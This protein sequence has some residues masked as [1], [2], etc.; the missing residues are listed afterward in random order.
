MIEF[1]LK[2]RLPQHYGINPDGVSVPIV[3]KN[4]PFTEVDAKACREASSNEYS[5]GVFNKFEKICSSCDHVVLKVDNNHHE[6]T[7]VKFEQYVN[8]LPKRIIDRKKRCDLL[9]TDG[10][11]HNKIVFC[12]LCCYD[13][14]YI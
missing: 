9:M 13:D 6:I 3:H 14:Y 8:S 1:L 10:I 11:P 5:E 2:E 4:E 7:V 12:D